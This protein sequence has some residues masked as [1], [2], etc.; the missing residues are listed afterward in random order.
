MCFCVFSAKKILYCRI[1]APLWAVKS[2]SAST[3]VSLTAKPAILSGS[4][5]SAT[6]VPLS[7]IPKTV[8]TKRRALSRSRTF[9]SV[10]QTTSRVKLTSF[11]SDKV[12]NEKNKNSEEEGHHNYNSDSDLTHEKDKELQLDESEG[13]RRMR[14]QS[15]DSVNSARGVNRMITD[16]PKPVRKIPLHA[17]HAKILS[18][19]VESTHTRTYSSINSLV[20]AFPSMPSPSQVTEDR[21]NAPRLRPRSRDNAD[22]LKDP[23]EK[24]R[25]YVR[26]GSFDRP[27]ESEEKLELSSSSKK[28]RQLVNSATV[29]SPIVPPAGNTTPITSAKVERKTRSGSFTIK[30]GESPKK[31]LSNGDFY[32]TTATTNSKSN[33]NSDNSDSE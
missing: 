16:E 5:S 22:R 15:A 30:R 28:R 10:D 32:S 19:G 24:A 1:S 12:G 8:E 14:R 29:S 33:N 3:I 17:S 21:I 6:S 2:T 26:D 11:S 31:N 9:D 25:E 4:N 20:T 7:A 23:L 13:S 18:T 27:R